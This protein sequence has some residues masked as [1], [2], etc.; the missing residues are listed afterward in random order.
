MLELPVPA[1]H[2][3]IPFAFSP[4]PYAALE[5]GQGSAGATWEALL[6]HASP[7]GG[8]RGRSFTN[9]PGMWS[10]INRLAKWDVYYSRFA[11][12]SCLRLAGAAGHAR[13]KTKPECS[14]ESTD[15]PRRF[16]SRIRIYDH[17]SGRRLSFWVPRPAQPMSARSSIRKGKPACPGPRF[18]A[19]SS[20]VPTIWGH[21]T[22]RI[23]LERH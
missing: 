22:R 11:G 3:S 8:Q 20:A 10:I 18:D 16:P 7:L 17:R 9:K 12:L 14:L 13:L 1:V 23:K 4:A 2:F 21:G 19:H 5:R 6:P 15:R